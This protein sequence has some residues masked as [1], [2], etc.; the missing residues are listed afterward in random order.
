M[1]NVVTL[2]HVVQLAGANLDDAAPLACRLEVKS[3]RAISLLL[4]KWREALTVSE[5]TLLQRYC[6]GSVKPDDNDVFPSVNISS[7][8]EDCTGLFLKSGSSSEFSFQDANG[9]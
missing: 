1:S 6:D 4:N 2:E 9:N 5:R 3:T 8:F 7:D